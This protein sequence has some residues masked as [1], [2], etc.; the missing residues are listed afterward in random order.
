M[1]VPW[2]KSCDQPSEWV[3]SLSSVRLFA[4]PWTVAYQAP[5]IGFSRQEYWSGLPLPSP[6]DLPDPGIEPGS[7]AFQADALTR[8]HIKKQRHYF[9]DKG[10]SSQN[11]GSSSSHIWK[12]EL[13][14]KESWVP[15]S[16]CFWTVVLQKTLESPWDC[17]EAKLVNR[18]GISPEYSLEGLI[19]NLKLQYFGHLMQTDSLEKTWCGERLKAQ[20]EGD[21]RGWDGWMVSLTGWTWVWALGVGDGQRNLVFFSHGVTKSQTWLSE[22]T[23]PNY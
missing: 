3:K 23:E 11:Y 7:P 18:K 10:P 2:K 8:G 13:A 1:L 4:T 12:W 17:K 14:H 21:N 19:L 16:Q 15:K 22:W 9:A 6:G 5:S 20:R